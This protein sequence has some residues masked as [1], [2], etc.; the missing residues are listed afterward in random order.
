LT[1]KSSENRQRNGE[2]RGV[3]HSI[4]TESGWLSRTPSLTINCA[5]YA[6]RRIGHERR[7]GGRRI[8]SA[9]PLPSGAE[10]SDHEK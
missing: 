1:L 4:V 7:L 8:D 3:P 2:I 9:A 10:S 6:P 5:T